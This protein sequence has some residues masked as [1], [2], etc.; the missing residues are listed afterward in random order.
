MLGTCI[1]SIKLYINLHI[2]HINLHILQSLDYCYFRLLFGI[3]QPKLFTSKYCFILSQPVLAH[4]CLYAKFS[5][6][7]IYL[8]YC[9]VHIVAT[10]CSYHRFLFTASSSVLVSFLVMTHAH[11]ACTSSFIMHLYEIYSDI[12]ACFVIVVF[13]SLFIRFLLLNIYLCIC[14]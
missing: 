14:F 2:V 13:F 11:L 1:F 3:Q 12:F 5:F 7:I 10:F 6:C 4:V 9:D 8:Q